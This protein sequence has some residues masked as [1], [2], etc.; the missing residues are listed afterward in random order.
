M[1]DIHTHILPFIDDGSSSLE[2]SYKMIVEAIE[3]NINHIILTPHA[4]RE[5]LKDYTLSGLKLMFKEFKE[6]ALEKY[7]VNLYLG[8][9]LYF[10]NDLVKRLKNKEFLTLNDSEFILLELP[11]VEKPEDL[12]E[13]IHVV[14]V[15]KLKIIL[16]HVERYHYLKI[17]DIEELKSCGVLMQINSG[18]LF[19]KDKHRRNFIRKMFKKNLVDFIASDVHSF[20][21]NQMNDA[22][23]YVSKKYG[24]NRA[25]KLFF[26]NQ[27]EYLNIK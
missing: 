20:R 13:I 6:Q 3:N 2:D 15:L 24:E 26:L 17:K 8:Q 18:S 7:R 11:F 21:K 4:F 23:L 22:Y 5:D 16:A 12:D 27:R 14:N 10:A 9:E 1:I 19:T 25:N